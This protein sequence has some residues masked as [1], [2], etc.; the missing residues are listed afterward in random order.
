MCC[1]PRQMQQLHEEELEL[2]RE[3][4]AEKERGYQLKIA[5]Y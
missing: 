5:E 1:L 3:E 4:F 2:L